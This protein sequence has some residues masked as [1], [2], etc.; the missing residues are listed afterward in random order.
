[1]P[2]ASSFPRSP[3]R[4][5]TPLSPVEYRSTRPPALVSLTFSSI[6]LLL[7]LLLYPFPTL[8]PPS[9]PRDGIVSQKARDRRIEIG[10]TTSNNVIKSLPKAGKRRV[11]RGETPMKRPFPPPIERSVGGGKGEGGGG[12]RMHAYQIRL[13]VWK[14]SNHL[15]GG[16]G[17]FR[18]GMRSKK[19]AVCGEEAKEVATPGSLPVCGSLEAARSWSGTGNRRFL[20]RRCQRA[21]EPRVPPPIVPR[22]NGPPF[23]PFFPILSFLLHVNKHRTGPTNPITIEALIG[24]RCVN[25]DGLFRRCYR[26]KNVCTSFRFHVYF[27]FSKI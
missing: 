13:H 24:L 7:L 18:D 23:T 2:A 6:S 1:M 14:G 5:I 17:Y 21:G 16:E 27:I 3:R 11:F 8:F 9:E 20:A 12:R 25:Y 10:P 15:P 26:R 4:Y 19:R 22:E